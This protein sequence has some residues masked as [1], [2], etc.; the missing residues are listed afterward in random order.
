M[1]IQLSV[2]VRNAML[3]AIKDTVGS[4]PKIYVYSGS[5]PASCAASASGTLLGM[6]NGTNFGTPSD[7]IISGPTGSS[8]PALDDLNVGHFRVLD[9]TGTTCHIQGNITTAGGGGDMI[10]DSLA[11]YSGDK[12]TPGTEVS[13][14]SFQIT[15][16]NA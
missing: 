7:G 9:S 14:G 4:S 1:A 8:F 6:I 16:G 2:A 15:E 13:V 12:G 5:Q 11:V 10:V 3:Q